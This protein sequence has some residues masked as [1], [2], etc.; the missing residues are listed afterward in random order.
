MS[1]QTNEYLAEKHAN[2][3]YYENNH[4]PSA[5]KVPNDEESI[6]GDEECNEEGDNSSENKD[7]PQNNHQHSHQDNDHSKKL[8]SD[9]LPNYI[10]NKG[11][12]N[13]VLIITKFVNWQKNIA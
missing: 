12:N 7:Y 1:F 10:N 2:S 6:N 11:S 8:Q 4:G 9:G 3:S 5:E 13:T